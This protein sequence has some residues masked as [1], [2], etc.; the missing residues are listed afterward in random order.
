MVGPV[1][2][3]PT[4]K[5]FRFVYISALPGPYH[6]PRGVSDANPVIKEDFTSSGGLCTFPEC[7]PGLA[8]DCHMRK[9]T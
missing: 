6:H 2:I 3:E 1:G 8:Q 9:R 4:T 7:T 5:A